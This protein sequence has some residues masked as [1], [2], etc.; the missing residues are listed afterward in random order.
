MLA[1]C[2]E[3]LKESEDEGEKSVEYAKMPEI[4]SDKKPNKVILDL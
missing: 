4:T 1:F 3:R 2:T